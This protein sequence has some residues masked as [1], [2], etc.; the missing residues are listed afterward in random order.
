MRCVAKRREVG[1]NKNDEEMGNNDQYVCVQ[2]SPPGRDRV[3][4]WGRACAT[5]LKKKGER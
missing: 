2:S 3:S 1:R 4:N 5:A